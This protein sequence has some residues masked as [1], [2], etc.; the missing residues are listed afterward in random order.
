MCAC[1]QVLRA[2]IFRPKEL[3]K[4]TKW[5]LNYW[6]KVSIIKLIG[7]AWLFFVSPRLPRH[8]HWRISR[9]NQS[10][11]RGLLDIFQALS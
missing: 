1:S 4:K 6:P 2:P 5:G 11:T 8:Q 7:L 9:R 3:Y 10:L